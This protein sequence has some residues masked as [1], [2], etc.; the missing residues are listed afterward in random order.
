[1]CFGITVQSSA[2]GN[3]KYQL[4]FNISLNTARTDGPA[5]T[6]DLTQ[7][8]GIDLGLYEAELSG[9]LGANTLVNNAILQVATTSTTNFFQN[10]VSPVHQ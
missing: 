8:Q 2:G 9:M 6:L 1:M 4:R 7:D 5:T 3:Y 10:K